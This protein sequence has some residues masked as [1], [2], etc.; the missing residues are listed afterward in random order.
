MEKTADYPAFHGSR[1]KEATGGM[2]RPEC[3]QRS[4]SGTRSLVF[5]SRE[6]WASLRVTAAA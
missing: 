3:N 2:G 5:Q 6:I 1:A 4:K